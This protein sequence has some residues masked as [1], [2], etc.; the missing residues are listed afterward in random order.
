[1]HRPAFSLPNAWRRPKAAD[2]PAS[3]DRKGPERDRTLFQIARGLTWIGGGFLVASAAVIVWAVFRTVGV[4]DLLVALTVAGLGLG[5]PAIVAFV[6]AWILNS[7]SHP[8][9]EPEDDTAQS[10]VPLPAGQR[11][12]LTSAVWGYAVAVLACTAAW[13]LRILLDPVLGQQVSYAPLLLSV[14]FAAW[15][16]GLGPAVFATLL[17]AGIAW[18]GYLSPRDRFGALD[19][20]DAV[21]LGLYC[22]AA[23]CI[24]AIASALR[25]SRERAQALA[26][27]SFA[28]QA[29]LERARAELAAER[30]RFAVTLQ[31]IADA[32]IATD[33]QGD[34]TFANDSATA[35]TGWSA[36]EAIGRPLAKVF[37]ALDEHTRRNVTLKLDGGEQN[38]TSAMVLVARDGT[39]RA[40]EPKVS[41][42]R[43]RAGASGGF[44]IVFRDITEA[45]RAR[46]ALEES[47]ARFRVMADQTPLPLWMSDTDRHYVYVNRAWLAFTGRAVDEELGDGWT[48]S[49][50]P[51]D[52]GPR[53]AAFAQA[54]DARTP[55]TLEYRLRRHDGTYRWM[56]DHGAPRFDGAGNFAGYIGACLDVTERK[57][58]AATLGAFEQRKTAFLASLAHELRNPLA[59]IQSSVELLR[60]IGRGSDP[61]VARAQEIIERNCARL[62]ALVDDLLDLSRIDSGN[63]QL[64]REPVDVAPVVE[65]AVA[66]H[67]A[68]LRDRAQQLTLDLPPARLRVL[69]DADRIEQIVGILVGNASRHTPREGRIA[70]AARAADEDAVEIAVADTGEGIEPER[71]SELFE[72]FDNVRG[73]GRA[74]EGLGTGLAIVA[75]LARLLGG[76]VRAGSEGRDRGSTFVLRL[77]GTG[78]EPATAP[79]APGD[80][81]GARPVRLLVVDDNVDAADAI[82]TLLAVEGFEVVTAH[83]PEAA[84]ERARAGDPD[85][86]LLDIGLP[87]M[88]GYELARKLRAAPVRTRAKLV[89]ITGYGQA[90]DTDT[91]REAGF[92][93]Y[94]VK[95]VDLAQLKSSI[96]ALLARDA[97][98]AEA[99][100]R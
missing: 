58:A 87:G 57:Q 13:G 3:Q 33:A 76:S 18:F 70:V 44:V 49:I 29:G 67:A 6:V 24:G 15:Y 25:A 74:T 11:S 53:Q 21:Q 96:D 73:T 23:L 100:R 14:A 9:A 46:A 66:R 37:R 43:G 82:G 35:L 79:P 64:R 17:G 34:I 45:R 85:V 60:H 12:A 4:D 7:L 10:E 48:A 52:F 93:G 75:R 78:G 99:A 1:M 27:E 32:V 30:D 50:H 59:P 56:L 80:A 90:T 94:L 2:P 92:D 81:S 69:G 84:I 28:R 31:S 89:A 40:V 91:A 22:A 20:D 97:P 72:L 41:R 63:I 98:T 83:D 55:F 26:R 39:E 62:A 51:E 88:T 38:E 8:D 19:I 71:A 68:A 42:I 86:I 65:R 61:R 36:T 54:F 77:Q 16:G 5:L 95:P 47:E